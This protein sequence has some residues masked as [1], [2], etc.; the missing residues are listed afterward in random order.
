M[1]ASILKEFKTSL[2]IEKSKILNQNMSKLDIIG[3]YLPNTLKD[4]YFFFS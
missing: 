1:I 4:E 3:E 2:D